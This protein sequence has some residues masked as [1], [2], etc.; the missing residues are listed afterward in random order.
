MARED[1]RTKRATGFSVPSQAAV[2]TAQQLHD[3]AFFDS[4]DG[5]LHFDNFSF[6]ISGASLDPDLSNYQVQ[7]LESLTP[8]GF[9]LVGQF[10]T[11]FH[12]YIIYFTTF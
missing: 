8:G 7:V 6:T 2:F 4:P 11:N 12:P 3:G 10:I 1:T 9:R 5:K